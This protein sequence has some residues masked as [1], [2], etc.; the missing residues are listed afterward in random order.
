MNIRLNRRYILYSFIGLS[1]VSFIIVSEVW[2]IET[3]LHTP[4]NFLNEL[5]LVLYKILSYPMLALF[6]Y[7]GAKNWIT[8][9]IY[10]YLLSFALNNLIYAIGIERLLFVFLNKKE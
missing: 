6:E 2:K 9:N 1:L 7:F 4:D 10:W 3:M 5:A 8:P